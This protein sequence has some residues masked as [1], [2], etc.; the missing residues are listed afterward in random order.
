MKLRWLLCTLALSLSGFH[1]G[2]KPVPPESVLD[3]PEIHIQQGWRALER[4]DLAAAAEQFERALALDPEA[5]EAHSGLALIAAYR[6]QFDRAYALAEK[7][8]DL[9]DKSIDARITLGRIRVLEKKGDDWLEKAVKEYDRALEL[10]PQ[11][12]KTLYYKGMAYKEAVRFDM[13]GEAF[14]EVV[15][16]K[17]DF[18]ARA[19]REW[20]LIQIIERA[21]PGTPMGAEIALIE[22]IDRADLAVL[23]IE[24]LKLIELLDKKRPPGYDTAFRAPGQSAE[25]GGSDLNGISD[26]SAHWAANWIKEIVGAN[27]MEVF[28]DGTFRPDE[29]ITRAS[30]ALI[31][32]NL[33]I[34]LIG[35]E[36]LA[37]KYI[38]S[39]SRFPDVAPSH[40][41]Y[42]A[43]CLAV[44]RNIIR[45]ETLTGAFGLNE[46]V[47]GA[48]ALLM[49]RQFQNA[50]RMT[51]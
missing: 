38:G 23:L 36:S 24:E 39:P 4:D 33:L 6:G 51:F 28:P 34:V 17:G 2:P 11:S 12:E 5:A 16:Q 47:S 26:I 50:L 15:A 30:Y 10:N 22:A 42:N 45:P 7:G 14:R 19:N 18:A 27:G 43:A 40:W 29:K 46:Q 9:D 32:Q 37:T 35:D 44:D 8:V 21:A 25:A 13:A 41:A 1:C 49:I 31:L 3:R 20:E 48:E